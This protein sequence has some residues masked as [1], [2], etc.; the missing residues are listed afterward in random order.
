MD[1]V[2]LPQ[3]KKLQFDFHRETN[4]D[5]NALDQMTKILV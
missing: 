1:Q 2:D 3:L 5:I 4:L